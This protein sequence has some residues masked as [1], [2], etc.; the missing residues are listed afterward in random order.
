MEGRRNIICLGAMLSKPEAMSDF[1]TCV[2]LEPSG[3]T[4]RRFVVESVL[5]VLIE[6]IRWSLAAIGNNIR[7]G[8]GKRVFAIDAAVGINAD[9][10]QAMVSF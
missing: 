5:Q 1:K 6:V 8:V 9:G 4:V 10:S 3:D 2:E 7:Y